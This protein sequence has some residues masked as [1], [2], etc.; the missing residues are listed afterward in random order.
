MAVE[1][2][3]QITDDS[4]MNGVHLRDILFKAMLVVPDDTQGVEVCL[5]FYPVTESKTSLSTIW[6]RFEVASYNQETEEWIEHCTG[7]IA[8]NFKKPLNP[9]DGSRQEEIAKSEWLAF[10][11]ARETSCQMPVDLDPIYKH[12]KDIGINHGGPFR[13]LSNVTISDDYQGLMTGDI[14]V[15]DI[16]Q[17]MPKQYAHEHLIHPTT[18]DNAFQAVFAAIYDLNGKQMLRRGCIP[19]SVR[20]MW[21]STTE[22]SS[23]PGTTLRCTSEASPSL[24]GSFESTIQA[25]NPSN[26]S[27]KVFS[28]TGA[29]LAP[30]KAESSD[31]PSNDRR[32]CYAIQWHP[33]LNLITN[34]DLHQLLPQPKKSPASYA[35]Q[36]EWLSK[37]QLAST[38]LAND[39]LLAIRGAKA[40]SLGDQHIPYLKL[41][42][43]IAADLT[44][45]AVPY[46][47][48]ETWLKYS[49]NATLKKQLYREV[50]ARNPEGALL[51]KMAS[52]VSSILR[53]E[54]TIEKLLSDM[55]ELI[56]AWDRSSL[57]RGNILPTLTQ[58]L[59]LLRQNHRSVRILDVQGRTG[60][61]SEHVLKLLSK[62][63]DADF[64]EQYVIG[65]ASTKGF[66][67]LKRRLAVWGDVVEYKVL[68]LR[69]DPLEQG[70]DP[71]SF[72]FVI[73]NDS[74]RGIPNMEETFS[75]LNSLVKPGGRLCIL[76]EM[77]PETLHANV[78]FGFVPSFSR[79]IDACPKLDAFAH[80][81]DWDKALRKTGFSGID[82]EASSS[83]FAEFADFTLM[84]STA[85]HTT[86]ETNVPSLEVLIILQA[87][88]EISRLL[89]ERLIDT[90]V[91]LSICQL[92]M[93]RP[94]DLANRTCISLLEAEEPILNG[95]DSCT[96][97]AIRNLITGSDSL[98]WVTGDPLTQ[99]E[100]QMATGLIRTVRWE[101]DRNNLNLVTLAL[102]GET[103][104]TTED[105]VDAIFRV[106][107]HQY[108]RHGVDPGGS[109][110]EYRVRRRVIETNHI[111]KDK[112]VS[113]VIQTQFERPK[114]I[115]RQWDAIERPVRL[116]NPQPGLDSL[117]WVTDE[118]L[119]GQPLTA[120]EIEIDV[121]AVGLNFKDLLVA[122]GEIDQPGFGHEAAGIVVAV[123]SSVSSLKAG[124]RVMC[125]GDPSP[126]RM[127]TLRTR[128]RTHAGLAIKIPDA[129]NFEIAAG[130]PIIYSTV[131][132]S[133]GH[134]ARLR[135]GEKI[136][137]H[138]AAG[139][140]GQAAIQYA[141]VKGAE[142]FVTL[143]SIE[144]KQFIMEN[145][146][147]PADHIFS[148]R[149]LTFPRGIKQIAPAG[150]DVV[151][152]SLSG[153]ALRQSWACIAP[154]GRFVEIGKLDFQNGS[155]LDMSPF[156]NNVTFSGVDLNALAEERPQIC[157]EI[158]QEVMR[159]WLGEKI[160]EARPTHV[161]EYGQLKEG[162]RLLQTGKSIG[163][164]TLIPGSSPVS[165]L[166]ERLPPL[167][168]DPNASFI[169]AGGLG[170]IGRSIALKLARMGAKHLIF[171]SRSVTV[172]EA[173]QNT[174][175][176]LEA[177]GCTSHVFQCDISDNARLRKVFASIKE[178][179]P[180][181]KGC[182]QCCF[183]LRDGAFDSMTHQDWKTALAP[184]VSGSWNLHTLLPDVDFFLML[185]SITGIVGN[186]SQAN[187]NAGNNFQDALARHRVSKGMHGASVN[188]GAV[189][190][191]GFVAE[192]AEYA[193]KHTFKMANQQTED[194]VLAV[195]E[196]M[197]DPR[198]HTALSPDNAQL[199]C[200]LRTPTS[201][202]L[203]NEDQPSHL[204]YPMFSQLPPTPQ[205]IS[206]DVGVEAGKSAPLIRD[207]LQAAATQN[208]ASQVIH[209][210]LRNKM[211]SLL[212]VG[213]DS[214]DDSLSVRENGVDSLIEMEFRTWF[215]KELGATVPLKDLAKDLKQLSSRLVLLSSFSKFH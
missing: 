168:L 69:V 59:T 190:D 79:A 124:D 103:T 122:M 136:L 165:V 137:I 181:V 126:G 54:T 113:T 163:K 114:A 123:G 104:A 11:Q 188:L 144:K 215:A 119:T 95:L 96:Y 197:I 97:Q 62:N 17:L 133:L 158:L 20:E 68:D 194:E 55:D 142:I 170:G 125:L 91:K 192:N 107:Q 51:I 182:I 193:G 84:M 177:L 162:M 207:Q 41:L 80:K 31:A 100:F 130:L 109:N 49:S 78:S 52:R 1:A 183:V 143:S 34:K 184:K 19:S 210:A 201:Y 166:P 153:E 16:K 186:R 120:D 155:K 140:V 47:S 21:L 206:G 151:L 28:L 56:W 5:S 148:S 90:G 85:K 211:A 138:A 111:V 36:L 29:Q 203:G 12:L 4:D 176:K 72:D 75:R 24:H 132:Y 58:F 129:L 87:H 156:L 6:R 61:L 112:T 53:K 169:L 214:F 141:Q 152:N 185:S 164:M 127:G 179:L 99:P 39:S 174:I 196:Y 154:F 81:S 204:Q 135:A 50:E 173:G 74:V 115:L 150:V 105:N 212:N 118:E 209:K 199:V 9:I 40:A 10:V 145:F 70:F 167:V 30:F 157:Q 88:S 38:L 15:P 131:I 92:D 180:P 146:K 33:A 187:Y 8:P 35:S 60:A 2:L 64:V 14:V 13:H 161:S 134:I 42:R 66:E 22:L 149:D 195:I 43:S 139:G 213:E 18:L 27:A 191:I 83:T 32:T 101:L 46:V 65:S 116:V 76:E 25:W 98:L 121:R 202:N 106:F 128:V 23:E 208:D 178:D 93:L 7:E 86:Q 117:V 175:A 89:T 94:E 63:N 45:D 67:A 200:G 147:I 160:Q 37:L 171:L 198:H 159:L 82:F 172:H 205:G 110:A 3:Q 73:I 77:R 71:N 57:S 189:V 26:P 44:I 102:D 48:L 108:L